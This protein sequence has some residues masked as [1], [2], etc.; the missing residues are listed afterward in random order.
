[1][2]LLL[3]AGRARR[4]PL[5]FHFA[6]QCVAWGAVI[7]ALAASELRSLSL[8]DLSGATRLDRFLWLNLGLDIGYVA[9]GAAIAT[10]AWILGRRHGGVGAG[11][12]IIVQ[13]LAL[14]ILAARL[15]L[16]LE[17]FA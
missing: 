7:A 16:I 11:V 10:S 9:V 4:S 6:A 5:I 14:A 13:G 12:A 15:I 1:L 2:L 8:R 3:T 17:Q